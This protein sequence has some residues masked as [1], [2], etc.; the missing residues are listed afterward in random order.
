LG[1]TF[2]IARKNARKE[3]RKMGFFQDNFYSTKVSARERR[4][5]RRSVHT[6]QP[7]LWATAVMFFVLGVFVTLLVMRPGAD[8]PNDEAALETFASVPPLTTQTEEPTLTA[9]QL[10]LQEMIIEAANRAQPSVVS[11]I[12]GIRDE[13]GGKMAE[14]GL[15]S[16]I[17]FEKTDGGARVVTNA[18]VI[19]VGEHVDVV[20]HTG[21]RME[22]S[23]VGVDSLTDLAVL[24]IKGDKLPQAASFGDSSGLKAGQLAIA[25]GNPLG[26]GYSHTITVGVIS[27]P[28]REIDVSPQGSNM[29][30]MNVIQ[31]DA[32]INQGNSGGALVNLAGEVIGINSLKV[33]TMGVEGLGFAIPINDA[34]P[35]IRDLAQYGKVIRPYLGIYTQNVDEVVNREELDLPEEVNTGIIVLEAFGPA[36]TAGIRSGDVIVAL[37]GVPTANT[38]ELRKYLYERK[39]IGDRVVVSYYRK[40]RLKET[41]A[42]LTEWD[43][44]VDQ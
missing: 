20:L 8:R 42:T 34:K 41:T 22:A 6:Q 24:E 36:K 38:Y 32:A 33:L 13:D 9:A 2:P 40:G 4:R 26:L 43:P 21:E 16:G 10:D 3:G 12:S 35:I 17:I 39:R 23:I 25:I 29:W 19:D 5:A 44:N 18:H 15:G 31:T 28:S 11:V 37:D 14:F 30:K 27:A 1:E 7:P